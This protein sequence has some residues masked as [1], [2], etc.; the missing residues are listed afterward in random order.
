MVRRSP[1]VYVRNMET[2]AHLVAI[3]DDDASVLRALGRVVRSLGY[4][5]LAYGT[6]EALLSG[7]DTQVPNCA[8]LDQHLPGLTGLEIFEALKASGEAVPA[9]IVTAND[10]SGLG[11]RCLAAGIAAYILKPVDEEALK[12]AL[13]KACGPKNSARDVTF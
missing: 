8:I 11:E 7:L 6:G 2:A 3:V 9:I 10:E 5:T 13:E 1:F 12:A 4:E